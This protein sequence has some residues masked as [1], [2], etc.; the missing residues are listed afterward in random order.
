MT[1]TC[2]PT[3]TP[4]RTATTIPSPTPGYRHPNIYQPANLT[5]AGNNNL[6]DWGYTY[7]TERD[8]KETGESIN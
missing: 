4:T 1:I 3:R 7:I 8:V 6:V 5:S 2:T